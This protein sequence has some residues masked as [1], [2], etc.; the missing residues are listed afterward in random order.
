MSKGQ[1]AKESLRN[2]SERGFDGNTSEVALVLG[3]EQEEIDAILADKISVDEDLEMK[4][5]GIADERGI[6]IGEKP[7]GGQQ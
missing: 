1:T 2:L 5:Y 7:T 4:V 3:R 6:A